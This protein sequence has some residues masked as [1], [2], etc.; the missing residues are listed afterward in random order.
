MFIRASFL[1]FLGAIFCMQSASAAPADTRYDSMRFGPALNTIEHDSV[2]NPSTS[3]E[4]SARVQSLFDGLSSTGEALNSG[5]GKAAGLLLLE[6][7][8]QSLV[9]SLM[10]SDT[11]HAWTPSVQNLDMLPVGISS[12]VDSKT[13]TMKQSLLNAGCMAMRGERMQGIDMRDIGRNE[14]VPLLLTT[15]QNAARE[16]GLPFLS[17][18]EIETGIEDGDY[19]GSVTTIQPLW[20]DVTNT[21][22]IFS[23]LSWYRTNDDNYADTLNAGLAYRHLNEGKD[24]LLGANIFFDHAYERNHNRMSLG[25]D[26]RTSLLGISAN[27]YIP[28]SDWKSLDAL[29]EERATAGWDLEVRGQVPQLPSWTGSLKGYTWDGH[30]GESDTYGV[31]AGVEYSPV[32]A[33]AVRAAVRNETH[34]DPAAEMALRF[35]WRFDQP[36]DLQFRPRLALS[37][38]S[39]YVYD[40]V[41]RENRIR[42]SQRLKASAYL[43]VLENVGANT[44]LTALGTVSVS[45]GQTLIV[46]VTV[47]VANSVGAVMRLRFAD[48]AVLTLGQNTQVRIEPSVLTLNYG[49]MQYVSG[50]VT[51]TVAVPGGTIQ[52]LGTDI[53]VVSDGTDSSVRVRDGSVILTGTTSGQ[54]TLTPGE[55]GDSVAGIVGT[56]PAG[57]PAYD[58]HTDQISERIELIAP[59][60]EVSKAAPYPNS[61]PSIV[62][63]ASTVG[64]TVR[65][66]ANFSK[67]VSVSG[68]TPRLELTVNG[69]PRLAPYTSGSGS[70]ALIF[71]YVLQAGDIGATSVTANG[72]DP[73]GANIY[74]DD[75]KLAVTTFADTS[76]SLSGTVTSGDVTPPS[77]YS[78]AFTTDPV[79]AANDSSAAFSISSAEVGATY[80]YSISSSGGGS[81]VTGSGTVVTATQ[82]VSGINLSGL[83]DGTLTVSVTL[84]DPSG[85]TGSAATDTVTKDADAPS[86][87]SAAFTT[88]PVNAGNATAAAFTILS[89]EV[90]TTYDYSV[91]SSGGGTAVTGSGTIATSTQSVTGVNVSGL[92]DGTLT[93]SVTLTDASGNTGAAATD[94][95]VKDQSAPTAYTV[96]FT[97]DPVNAGNAAATAFTISSAEVGSTYDYSITSSGGGT[98][99]TGSGTISTATQSV[100]GINVSG[101][102]DGTLTVSL[103]LTDTGGNTGTAATDTVT[104]D[105]AAPSGYSVAFTSDPVNAGN[106]TAAAFTIS[107]AEIGA[108]YNYSISSSGGGTAVTGTGTIS[109]A[110]QAITGLNVS[111]LTDGTLTVSVTLTDASGNAGTAA[112]DTV[113]KDAGAPSGYSVAFTTDPVNGSNVSAAAFTISAAETGTTYNYSITSS[114][115]GTAVTGSGTITAATQAVT[116]VNVTGLTDGTLT[117]SV[118]LTDASGNAGT[119]ATDTVT[120]DVTAPTIVSVTAPANGTYGP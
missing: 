104:K 55:M 1:S 115:G 18:L 39:D 21:H 50:G 96:L 27:R 97:T 120:K 2:L 82:S 8:C 73:N 71:N 59:P 88:D 111:G 65:I 117:V 113:I 43:A 119:A 112:T 105:A 78:V 49:L 24:L 101:L 26:A 60:L 66:A 54:V 23:Q 108:T 34:E 40:K 95:A 45:A 42:V 3:D 89:A 75:G 57:S 79:T 85:N 9:T 12:F 25:V 80:N 35:N 100:S 103:T 56:V 19:Y 58:A 33:L 94:T 53:D 29:Y 20:R 61:A 32:P 98:A 72:I 74:G 116:G 10:A 31:R 62:Q 118:T 92:A 36:A 83:N 41:Q 38:V 14:I 70:A 5:G 84:T 81:P 37:P 99:V 102:N 63:N 64:S 76:L 13:E 4:T 114:G 51:R 11:V 93:V 110:T 30:G 91:T 86:G 69:T 15:G 48:G 68:G 7:G 47:T 46:P 22:H 52:L 17:N 90:G 6:R 106:A 87:Y 44:A 77:G 109:T 16:S 28:L 107:S 67:P